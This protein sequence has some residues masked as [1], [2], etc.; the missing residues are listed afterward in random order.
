MIRQRLLA[1][2]IVVAGTLAATAA[3]A[4]RVNWSVGINAPLGNGVSVGTVFGNGM[5]VV[6][7]P[8]PVVY[9]PPPVVYAPAPVAYVPPPVA[10][11]PPP[12]PRIA[13]ASY[14]PRVVV[15]TPV[16][17]APGAYR[18]WH[19]HHRQHERWGD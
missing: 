17:V 6:V 19:R 4:E 7:A 3:H 8:V 9:A 2:A 10:Y 11:G 1:A 18:P 15:P 12:V 5:P 16:Y 13:Y 14:V